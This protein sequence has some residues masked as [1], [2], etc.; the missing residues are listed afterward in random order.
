MNAIEAY[1][2]DH[3]EECASPEFNHQLDMVFEIC[4]GADEHGNGDM[5]IT[6][7]ELWAFW[8]H[9]CADQG[10]EHRDGTE[11]NL[12]QIV[13]R[14]KL[15]KLAQMKDGEHCPTRKEFKEMVS[16]VSAMDA[17]KSGDVSWEEGK[18][19]VEVFCGDPA[20]EELCSSEEFEETVR[21]V[22][23]VAYW[24]DQAGDQ[25]GAVSAKEAWA[26][27]NKHCG[28]PKGNGKGAKEK[29]KGKGKK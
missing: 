26:L 6:R 16:I 29:G 28:G 4:S 21:D 24:A 5:A 1:C 15:M 12:G 23:E 18:A 17:D 27:F 8:N 10:D 20:N 13:S 7:D 22:A 2:K 25:N 9:H 3:G 19:A 11:Q 14:A